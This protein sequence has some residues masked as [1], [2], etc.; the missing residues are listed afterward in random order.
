MLAAFSVSLAIFATVY[1]PRL[2]NPLWSDVEFTGWVSP[3]A[4]RMVEG[5]RIYRDFTLPIPPA[6]FALLALV[7][8][9]LGRFALLDELWVCALGQM[10]MLAAAWF[11]VRA[12]SSERNATLVVLVTSPMLIATPK[13]IAYDQTALAVAWVS[14]A[15]LTQGLLA[16]DAARRWKWLAATGLM[17]GLVLAFK[18]STG[19]GA[20][21]GAGLA[22]AASSWMAW[23][24]SGR[25]AWRAVARDWVAMMAGVA[26]GGVLTVLLVVAVGGSVGEFYRVVFVDGPVLKGGR[27]Q[28]LINLLSYTILQTPTHVS[29]L[30]AAVVGWVLVRV[31]GKRGALEVS[32]DASERRE[33][34]V[35]GVLFVLGAGGWTV[36][37]FGLAT[38]LLAGNASSIPVLLRVGAGFGSAIPM[39][40]LLFL[41]LLLVVNA[42]ASE[43]GADR[44]GAFAAVAIAAGFVSLAH[45]LSDPTHR[46]FY[47]NNPIIPLAAFSLLLAFDQARLRGLKA[48]TVGL[49]TMVL[50]GGKFERYLDARYPVG[51]EGFWQGLRVSSNGQTLLRAAARIRD[52]AGPRGTVL[53]LPEDPMFEA[54]VGRPR[55]KLQGA[56]VF[57][58][59]FPERLLESDLSALEHSPPDVVVLHPRDV[60]AWHTVY[61]IWNVKCAAAR[62][63]NEFTSRVLEPRYRRDSSFETWMFRGPGFMDVYTRAPQPER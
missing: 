51:P 4:H 15:L 34:G 57:V 45:N 61:S 33:R 56:I 50:F 62:L 48:I 8:S 46:P 16:R 29:L 32:A 59:Q 41:V 58:D 22:L 26:V 25:D 43:G 27:G 12:L 21:G 49:M 7:Q 24:R 63:Q 11:I 30:S 42:R 3:I 2:A 53:M 31:L 23:R 39:L 44:R 28:V 38:L 6:S 40:G 55:P 18:S 52:L 5:Q 1:V 10:V 47:D 54:L 35:P 37:M 20:I 60:T 9:A 17:S 13:E 14:L 36:L 19:M